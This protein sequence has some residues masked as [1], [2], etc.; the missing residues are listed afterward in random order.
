VASNNDDVGYLRDCSAASVG[1]RKKP[2][3]DSASYSHTNP[4]EDCVMSNNDDIGYDVN[5][6][7]E[8][9]SDLCG[10]FAVNA[11]MG[12]KNNTTEDNVASVGKK[13]IPIEDSASYSQN[14]TAEDHVTNNNDDVGYEVNN[15]YESAR[16]LSG[17]FAVNA[18]MGPIYTS[19]LTILAN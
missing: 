1:N 8:S 14:N 9:A 19:P 5:N 15:S 18:A 10:D 12:D 3:E 7:Y 13:K 11:A 16:K 6:S 2:T 17:D 4:T